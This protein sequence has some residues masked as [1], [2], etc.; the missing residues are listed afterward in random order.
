MAAPFY[1]YGFVALGEGEEA[2]LAARLTRLGIDQRDVEVIGCEGCEGIAALAS[3]TDVEVLVPDAARLL[4]HQQVLTAAMEDR[5]VLP[6]RFGMIA[7][8]RD[9]VTTLLLG[10]RGELVAALARLEGKEEAGLKVFWRNEAVQ[11]EI[12]GELGDLTRMRERA[13]DAATA[14]LLAIQVGQRVEA[15]VERWRATHVKKISAE[16]SHYYCDMRVLEPVGLRMLW[17]AAFLIERSRRWAFMEIVHKLDGIYG[18]RLE[19]KPVTGLPPYSFSDLR[20]TAS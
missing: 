17:N 20:L 12:E 7:P 5:A 11:K 14:R 1:L 6:C 3:P 9:R 13:R 19:F 2:S 16:M 10:N 8:E 15:C 18:D 4:A